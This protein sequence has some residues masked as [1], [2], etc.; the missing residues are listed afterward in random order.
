MTDDRTLLV[1]VPGRASA[2]P[3][4]R[5]E[6]CPT[7]SRSSSGTSPGRRRSRRDAHRHRGAAVHGRGRPARRARRRRRRPRAVAVD[8]LRRHRRGPAA[9]SRVRERGERARD[10]HRRAHARAR[11]RRRSGASPTSSARHPRAAGPPLDTRASPTAACCSSATAA[12][13]RPIEDR[14]AP[15]EVELTRVASRARDDEAG[16]IHGIDELPQ[17]LPAAEIVIVGV[18]LNESTTGLVDAAFLAATARR[19]APRQHRAR[20]G[21]RHG[22]DP[23]RGAVGPAALRARRHRSRAAARRASA[24]RACRTC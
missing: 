17:L 23:R 16:R 2:A 18:P 22:G 19:R 6:A 10:L 11:A 8:R 20:Q 9:G 21:R 24:L 5:R 12:S 14:L 7:G 1:T 13:A 3:S 15:F 4:T